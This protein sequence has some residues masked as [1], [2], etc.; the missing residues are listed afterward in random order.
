VAGRRFGVYVHIPFCARRCDYCAFA[1]W[2]D[3]SHL[4]E[5]YVDAL[6][7]QVEQ[8]V[9][10]PGFAAGAASVFVGGG[11]PSLLPGPSLA[12]VLRAIPTAPDAEIT[13]ECN[14]D[15]VTESLLA[16]YAAAGVNR[17]SFGVQS[18]VPHVLASLGR[19]HEPANVVG[20]VAA[21]R[22]VGFASFNLDL[23]YGAR[24]ESLSDWSRTVDEVLALEPAHISAY[25]LTVEPGTPL[26]RDD[27][28]HPD[29]DDQAD[30]YLLATERFA[31]AGL[32]WYEISNWARPGARCRHNLL[33][34]EQGDYLAIG[35]AAHGHRR[36]RRWW[37]VRTPERFIDAIEH[38]RS[39]V[40]GGEELDE[41]TRA[42]ERW[43]L[44]LRTEEGVPA[45]A[46]PEDPA[47]DAL[48]ERR[49]DRVV[50]TVPGRLLA[51]EV[52]LR[53]R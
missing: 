42:R 44:A 30:K 4:M 52:A 49:E 26:A 3:R 31:A 50:L 45:E 53:L 9:T 2:T 22:A 46:L 43:Q 12:R 8:T 14:P 10:A 24:G 28:R 17:L 27:A 15:N 35:C 39:A 25:A 18:M 7:T 38:G 23:I 51:N 32:E 37:N 41:E 11:T 29:G 19:T 40:G 36:G 20:A 13:V 34:W 16:T 21:A 47:I 1:T 48:I 5:R 6:V 33:Y